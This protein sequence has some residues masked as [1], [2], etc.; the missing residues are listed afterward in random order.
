MIDKSIRQNY[1]WGGPGGKSPG[2]SASHG[3]GGQGQGRSGAL[4]QIAKASAR[5][6]R[7]PQLGGSGTAAQAA[8]FTGVPLGRQQGP[9]TT[10]GASPFAYT[11]TVPK[12][13]RTI[14]G[15]TGN[16]MFKKF[17]SRFD[18]RGTRFDPRYWS[19]EKAGNLSQVLANMPKYWD[20]PE[21]L[22]A[23]IKAGKD[24]PFAHGFK[25]K[26]AL[27]AAKKYG[28]ETSRFKKI[29]TTSEIEKAIKTRSL[30]S[31]KQAE[32]VFGATGSNMSDA[33]KSAAQYAKGPFTRGAGKLGPTSQVL[34]DMVNPALGYV[35]RGLLGNIQTRL[36]ASVVNKALDLGSPSVQ[37]LTSGTPFDHLGTRG[38][39]TKTGAIKNLGTFES[40]SNTGKLQTNVVVPKALRQSLI[41]KIGG[42]LL[43]GANIGLGVASAVGHAKAGD[44]GQALMAGISAVPGP[45]GWAGLAG[46]LGLGALA[47]M[48]PVNTSLPENTLV[49]N[50]GG[51]ASL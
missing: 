37:H 4:Q 51:L 13:R 34:R 16:D 42:R 44:Y 8:Q 1:Q 14:G 47:N 10:G 49:M 30:K 41:N 43:P 26:E 22:Q 32:G 38:S 40:L 28:F 48:G 20:L 45:V 6:A 12:G 21:D 15:I 17:I 33:L 35:D 5:T 25:T 29:P 2:T 18:P 31:L 23:L 46:E 50:R 19:D 36:P 24:I 9:V 11:R 3:Q 39:L 27:E 7:P